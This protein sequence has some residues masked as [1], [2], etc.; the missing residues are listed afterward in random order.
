MKHS[1]SIGLA[2]FVLSFGPGFAHATQDAGD[3]ATFSAQVADL[4]G[5]GVA[6]IAI[7]DP[8]NNYPYGESVLIHSGARGKFSARFRHQPA[9]SSSA[10]PS[11]R[12][13]MQMPTVQTT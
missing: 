2:A 3:F 4:D 9:I 7:S 12:P 6:D 11:S 8:Y 13:A 5:D 10:S 1:K